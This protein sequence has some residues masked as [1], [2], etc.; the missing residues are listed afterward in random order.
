M[1]V[2]E[3][4]AQRLIDK[5]IEVFLLAIEIYNKPTIKYRVE[6]F[7]LFVVNA[8]EL[9]LKAHLIKKKG[10]DSVYF[11]DNQDRT[12]SLSS[13]IKEIFTNEKDPLRIN[14]ERIV[15]LR[16]ISTHFITTEYEYVYIPLFQANVINFS[17]KLKEFHDVDI[18]DYIPENF[19]SLAVSFGQLSEEQIRAKY[20][21]RVAGKLIEMTNKIDRLKAE[22]GNKFAITVKHE[23]Y[24]T[25]NKDAS[26]T[27]RLTKNAED[28]VMI[29]KQMQ[30]PQNTHPYTTTS[31]IERVNQVLKNERIVLKYRGQEVKFN[32]HHFKNACKVYSIKEQEEFCYV[33]SMHKN[34]QYSYSQKALDFLLGLLRSNPDS[35]LDTLAKRSQSSE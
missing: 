23:H 33:Y 12:I 24:L 11:K 8:W 29:V 30:D 7:A 14:L 17:M 21:S 16:N 22:N 10:E 34:M 31:L 3:S 13:C 2:M 1:N 27:F 9:M 6:G 4:T 35:L 20:S 19:L 18:T 32:R 15:E 25:K 26:D 28:A 5:S